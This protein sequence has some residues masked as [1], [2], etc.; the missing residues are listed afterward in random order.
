MANGDM[1][2]QATEFRAVDAYVTGKMRSTRIPG[3]AV[4]I[5]RGDS[6][7]F[8]KRYGRADPSGRPVT[9]ETPFMIGSIT[10]P[11]TALAVMQLV[12]GGRIELDAPVRRYIPW[13]RVAGA[14]ASER[15]TVRQLLTMTSGLPQSYETQLWTADDSDAIERTVRH[16]ATAE[17]SQNRDGGTAN[18]QSAIFFDPDARVGVYIAANVVNALDTF[19]SPH[20]AS[21]LDGTTVRA[22][23]H[24]VLNMVTNQPLP[25]EGRGHER[26]TLAFNLV[27]LILTAALIAL[28]W[29]TPRRYVQLQ[30]Y[31]AASPSS[32]A[33]R[34][35]L[36]AAA[37]LALPAVVAYLACCVAPW[38]V[39][40]MFQSRS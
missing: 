21:P 30:R 28:L 11:F 9:L 5:V 32:L 26:L 7:V 35:G 8:M 40:A 10:K 14:E 36:A 39:I 34:G 16:M 2:L 23:A 4:A 18:F 24:V 37:Y 19:S 17:L 15:I 20:G 3:L 1:E 12:E 13:F 29:R 6:V 31:G 22:M 27:I 33:R 25:D 38:Q